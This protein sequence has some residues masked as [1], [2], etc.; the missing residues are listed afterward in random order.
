MKYDLPED[1][2]EYSL[3]TREDRQEELGR[4]ALWYIINAGLGQH[5]L[6]SMPALHLTREETEILAASEFD[7]G[8]NPVSHSIYEYTR[9]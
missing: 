1:P 8:T 7:P 4:T 2:T 9:D 5:F 6:R 3:G